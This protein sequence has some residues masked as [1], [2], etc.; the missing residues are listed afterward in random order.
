M[1][2]VVS[3]QSL[4]AEKKSKAKEA[5]AY[6]QTVRQKEQEIAKLNSRL[7]EQEAVIKKQM[8]SLVPSLSV[9]RSVMEVVEL[10]D[11]LGKA[12]D[13]REKAL[14]QVKALITKEVRVGRLCF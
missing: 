12:E 6:Q 4:S 5:E 14:R 13:E 10:R 3:P 9:D 11:L 2:C 8:S 7:Q 1:R